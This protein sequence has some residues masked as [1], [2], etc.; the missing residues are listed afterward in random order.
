MINSC[1]LI[2]I[3]LLDG[4]SCLKFKHFTYLKQTNIKFDNKWKYKKL[5]KLLNEFLNVLKY[6]LCEIMQNFILN[7]Y[8][9]F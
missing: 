9:T 8:H 3:T 6:L 2:L 1:L 4:V 7:V 5:Y